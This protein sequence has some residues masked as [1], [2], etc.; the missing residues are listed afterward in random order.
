MNNNAMAKNILAF[1]DK[2]E[3]KGWPN[4]WSNEFKP[5]AATAN[6]IDKTQSLMKG[7]KIMGTGMGSGVSG[8]SEKAEEL[9][10]KFKENPAMFD[11][12]IQKDRGTTV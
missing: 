8:G 1:A 11:E 5:F 9:F 10:N 3:E 4:T 6:A 2:M 7:G 12:M